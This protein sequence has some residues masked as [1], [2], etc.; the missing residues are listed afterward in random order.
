MKSDELWRRSPSEPDLLVSSQGKVMVAPYERSMPYGGKRWYGGVPTTGQ[1]DGNRYVYSRK[2]HKTL[3]VARLVCEAF[4][5]PPD[6]GQVAM[7]EDEDASNNKP[8]NLRWG[9]QKQ[10]LNYPGFLEHCRSRTG[11]NSSYRKGKAAKA[12]ST[13]TP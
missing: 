8:G 6:P 1:W 7:H 10:N 12:K 3:K 13:L 11:E 4:N 2:G 9:T 5:G